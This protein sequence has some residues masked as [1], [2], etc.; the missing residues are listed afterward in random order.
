[1]LALRSR[2]IETKENFKNKYKVSDIWCV[3]CK[4]FSCTQQHILFCQKIRERSTIE[5]DKHDLRM[6]MVYGNIDQ[7]L[8]ITRIYEHFLELRNDLLKEEENRC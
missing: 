2:S 1:M 8:K 3:L 5:I 7:Q 4:L 6:E